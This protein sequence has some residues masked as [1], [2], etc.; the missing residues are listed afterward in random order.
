MLF[1]NYT[2]IK[3]INASL[4]LDGLRYFVLTYKKEIKG[5]HND[6]LDKEV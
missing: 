2:I 1:Y 5:T 4:I 3:S 6:K